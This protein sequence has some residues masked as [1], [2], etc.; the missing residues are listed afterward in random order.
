MTPA[1]NG[2]VFRNSLFSSLLFSLFLF[3]GYLIFAISNRRAGAGPGRTDAGGKQN[4]SKT[5][6]GKG[7]MSSCLFSLP[8]QFI[9]S[10]RS[11]SFRIIYSISIGRAGR[12]GA[13]RNG[14]NA[15][16]SSNEGQD[17]GAGGREEKRD[18]WA[19]VLRRERGGRRGAGEAGDGVAG[20]VDR[21]T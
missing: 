5:G 17:R 1:G 3:S 8:T 12:G 2:H 10:S 11:S 19:G 13:G 21:G 20:G 15:G 14:T 18:G 9:S 7:Y 6:G 16:A 4:G